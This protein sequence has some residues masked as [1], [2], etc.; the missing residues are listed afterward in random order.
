MKYFLFS[1]KRSSRFCAPSISMSFLIKSSCLLFA[2]SFVGGVSAKPAE[3]HV[4]QD[5]VSVSGT[6]RNGDGEPLGQASVAV[7]GRVGLGVNT[8][9]R[10]AFQITVPKGSVLL[11]SYVGHESRE[12]VIEDNRTLTVTLQMM[13]AN[14]EQ[15]VVTAMGVSREKKSLGYSVQELG[16]DKVNEVQQPDLLNAMAGKVSGVQISGSN[17]A[18]GSSTQV[19]IRG[20]SSI[21]SNNQP[22]F[23][24]DG[25]PIDNGNYS[26]G[27][28]DYGNGASGVNPDDIASISVLKGPS[29]AALY[30]SRGANGVIMITTK[31]GK[32]TEGIGIAFNSSTVFTNPMRLPDYQNEYGQGTQGQFEFVD[33]KGG[34]LNDGVDESWGPRL[35]G[36]LLP[37]FNSPLDANGNRIPTP[38]VAHPDNVKNFFETGHNLTNNLSVTGANDKGDFR[39]SVGNLTTKGILPNTDYKRTS[40][41]INSGYKLTEKFSV[42]ASATYSKDGSNNRRN[43]G[44]SFVWF[45]RQVDL[46][47]L[48]DY[49]EPGSID[50]FNW[51][52]NYASNPYYTLN[53]STNFNEKDRLFGNITLNYD[54]SDKFSVMG[55]TGTDFFIDRRK[56]KGARY[57]AAQFGNYGEEEIFVRENNSDV[58]LT[59]KGDYLGSFFVAAN[60]GANLRTNYYQR[61]Y[62]YASELAI[63]GVY[64]LGNSRQRPTVEN[65]A[66]EKAIY[67]VY[68]SGQIGF[69]DYL[70]LDLTARNDWSSTLAKGSNSYFYPSASLSYVVSDM[71][72]SRPQWLSL[73]KLRAGYAKV[74]NDTE[75]YR[76]KQVLAYGDA[77]GSLP[78]V[79]VD[80]LLLSPELKPEI[81]TSYEAGAEASLFKGRLGFDLTYYSQ[82]TKNQILNA[83]VSN[84]SGFGS[85]LLNAGEVKNSGIEVQLSGK[86]VTSDAGFTWESTLNFARNWNEVVELASGLENFQLGT[87]RGMSIEARVGQPY[88]TFFG[89]SYLRSPEGEIVYQNGLPQTSSERKILGTFMPDWIG[90][91]TN[92]FTYR[93]FSL[94]SHIDVR[95]GG[96]IFS[97]DILGGRY[98]G[99]YKETLA[100]REEGIIGK[101]VKN[102]GTD[103]S[104]IYVENDELVSSENWHHAYHFYNNNEAGVFDATYIKMRELKL[105]Y[106]LPKRV[107]NQSPFTNV[108]VGVVGYNLFLIYSNIP[109]IDPET[110]QSNSG[111]N[112]RGIHSGQL[113]STRNIG[114]NINL[115]F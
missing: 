27:N 100:G 50:Q 113:P 110:S 72:Q 82:S 47:E 32:G 103:A 64:N 91:F 22:L 28:F 95:W 49:L 75:P 109:H 63:P 98:S 97:Y 80:N 69:K 61:N 39:L 9:E 2:G 79:T 15:V 57:N 68:A 14:L 76:L 94:Y 11:I 111:S 104:P 106:N 40:I 58:L 78:T 13:E 65:F 83:N 19:L 88:G 77:W 51:N 55:R 7:K 93:D 44:G 21:G 5:Q 3:L 48:Q 90:G 70:Y 115:T 35:D 31:S 102:V 81:T 33:G 84:A 23:V 12:F 36:R 34:G 8:D 53:E 30:G 10:G 45:G 46:S 37:Q 71:M 89:T 74:G 43:N 62:M 73:L 54:L 105:S 1:K 17:G 96:N 16:G 24:V 114:F 92:V 67:S 59:Y 107:L 99:Q 26:S 66:S 18:P 20:V 42:R 6:V 52:Y 38:W 108:S 25:V 41:G 86:P 60:A 56:R 87:I 4:V 29:A 101:G 85:V 112:A